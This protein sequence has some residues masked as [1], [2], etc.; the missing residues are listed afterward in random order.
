MGIEVLPPDLN[1]S[2]PLFVPETTPAGVPAIRFG[3]A[4]VKN[5]GEAAMM[6]C[7]REREE[8]GA[9]DS[10]ED[11]ANRLDS[12]VVNKRILE[13]LIKAGAMDWTNESR[14]GMTDRLE[15][16]IAAASSSHRDKAAGQV[17]MF[18]DVDFELL[19]A[20]QALHAETRVA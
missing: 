5:V 1:R 19:P 14:S 11:L 2:Q 9:F 16:V 6:A 18:G 10:M 8:N 4:A 13:N 12:K 15:Q 3:L 17:S 7:V 20:A